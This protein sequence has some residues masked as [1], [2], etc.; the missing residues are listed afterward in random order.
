MFK[1]SEGGTLADRLLQGFQCSTEL[2]ADCG[3]LPPIYA[4][5]AE[6]FRL[7][8]AMAGIHFRRY[9]NDPQLPEQTSFWHAWGAAGPQ[10]EDSRYALFNCTCGAGPGILLWTEVRFGECRLEFG[11]ALSEIDQFIN[12]RG[13]VARG[14]DVLK[15]PTVLHGR[16]PSV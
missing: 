8:G 7:K 11:V 16:I 3:G 13:A 2:M 9:S 14:P 1:D 12:I 6:L 5:R 4:D 10:P 15:D